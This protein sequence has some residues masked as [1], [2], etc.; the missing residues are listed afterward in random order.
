[1]TP[2]SPLRLKNYFFT[3]IE[4][5]AEE[6]GSLENTPDLQPYV[7]ASPAGEDRNSWLLTLGVNL[8]S[9]E[10]Q[11][12]FAYRAK[13]EIQGFV[14]IDDAY[15]AENKGELARINGTSLLYSAIREMVLNLTARSAH[16][17]LYL[18]ILNFAEIFAGA[19]KEQKD[20]A[21]SKTSKKRSPKR[22]NE[23]KA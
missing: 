22:T 9:H 21:T 3:H 4:L 17:P 16:G 14:T 20:K 1:M 23:N 2:V 5:T 13:F 18:P 6:D 10:P 15:P 8:R 7:Q 11:Q 12:P 19:E